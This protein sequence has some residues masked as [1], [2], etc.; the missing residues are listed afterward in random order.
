MA[1]DPRIPLQAVP[2]TQINLGQA[3]QGA[4]QLMGLQRNLAQRAA[5]T[6]WQASIGP[7]G[8]FNQAAFN[9]RLSQDPQAAMESN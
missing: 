7:N 3:V 5:G 8:Q 2:Q 9:Q 6:D 1:I 4:N